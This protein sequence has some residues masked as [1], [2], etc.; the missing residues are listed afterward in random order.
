[1]ALSQ[2]KEMPKV[3]EWTKDKIWVCF[4]KPVTF[5]RIILR[6]SPDDLGLQIASDECCTPSHRI[7]PTQRT[8]YAWFCPAFSAREE[9]FHAAAIQACKEAR[10]SHHPPFQCLASSGA[11]DPGFL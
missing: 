1:M 11:V 2:Q 8:S 10:A 3:S 5:H 4:S 7:T 9:T 6:A